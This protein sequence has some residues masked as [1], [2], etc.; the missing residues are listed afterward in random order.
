M[1]NSNPNKNKENFMLE[2]ISQ[3]E[4]RISLFE[5]IQVL[6]GMKKR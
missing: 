4:L 2:M 1:F 3:N 6:S 5:T